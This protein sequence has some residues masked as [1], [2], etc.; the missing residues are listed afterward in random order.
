MSGFWAPCPARHLDGRTCTWVL[1]IHLSSVNL[2]SFVSG[3]VTYIQIHMNAL[4]ASCSVP[5]SGRL[6]FYLFKK[7]SHIHTEQKREWNQETRCSSTDK[8]LS[9]WASGLSEVGPGQSH[10]CCT[11]PLYS[12]FCICVADEGLLQKSLL[13]EQ[14]EENNAFSLWHQGGCLV[15]IPA[16]RWQKERGSKSDSALSIH[17]ARLSSGAEARPSRISCALIRPHERGFICVCGWD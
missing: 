9:L 10:G 13:T 5:V 8:P 12:P 3:G 2:E 15:L 17:T 4:F 1:R 14:R 16:R 6:I 11:K 7:N